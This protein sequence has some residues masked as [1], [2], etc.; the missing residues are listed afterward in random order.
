MNNSLRRAETGFYIMLSLA[1]ALTGVLLFLPGSMWIEATVHVPDHRVGTD[2]V[3]QYHRSIRWTFTGR[4]DVEI[5]RADGTPGQWCEGTGTRVYSA[6]EPKSLP[7]PLVEYTG[8]P[9]CDLPVG[10]YLMTTCW[11][12]FVL[13]ASKTY[14]VRSNAFAVLPIKQNRGWP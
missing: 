2:P 1:V 13:F 6:S 14:C 4:F 9:A 11:S 10:R 7:L 12:W 3:V 5:H 8:A